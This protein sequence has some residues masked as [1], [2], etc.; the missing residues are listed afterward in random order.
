MISDSL[1]ARAFGRDPAAIGNAV[2]LDDR[3]VTIVGVL[4]D[5]ADFGMRQILSAAAYSRG[6]ADRGE[7]VRVDVWLPLQ[8]DPDTLPRDTHPVFQIG[9]LAAGATLQAAQLEAAGFAA[10]LERAYPSS[11]AGRGVFVEPFGEVVFGR[12]RPALVLLL[13]AVGFVLL[14]ACINVS[15]LVLARGT[16]RAREVAIRTVLGADGWRLMRQFL[17]EGLVLTLSG[18]GLG[19]AVA[20]AGLRGLVAIAPADVPRLGEVAINWTVLGATLA[21][22]V[23][24]GLAFGLVPVLQTRRLDPQ[25]ALKDGG[26]LQASAGRRHGRLR[27]GLVVIEIALAVVL[28][29]G[30]GLL[31]RSFRAL[32]VIDPGFHSEGVLKAEF[33]LPP[34]RYPVDFRKWPNFA[35]IHAFNAALLERA[36]ALPGVTSAAIAGNHPLDAGFTNSFS[37]VGREAEAKSWPEISV[38]R[39]T[40]AYF[41]VVRLPLV[42]GRLFEATDTTGAAPVALVNAAAARRFFAGMDPIGARIT[43]W[44]AQ[45]TVVGVVGDERFQGLSAAPP[46]GLYLP[47]SQAPSANGAGVLLVR[48]SGDPAAAAHDVRAAIRA[49]DPGLAVFGL[50]PLRDTVARSLSERAFTMALLALFAAL[51]IGLAALG[52]H[53]VLSYGVEQRAREIG[54]RVALGARPSGIMARVMGESLVLSAAG[55]AIGLAGAVVLTRLM[56]GLLFGVT[57][58]DP[59]TFGA[60]AVLLL[61]VAVTASLVPARRAARIDPLVTLRA[62]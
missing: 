18:A 40:P 17:V 34:T 49:I 31:V 4:P 6:F 14:V 59:L 41:Q 11:N 53:G 7:R 3:A 60:V 16:A 1:W 43:M 48:T 9:R 54:V 57:P 21:I 39:V 8:P 61:G 24:A 22:S 42:T 15:S 23:L 2:R 13:G 26:G 51:A 46:I 37:V 33:Q 56:S 55:L 30:A 47:L 52:V 12:V 36:E 19:V 58:T 62:E 5:A 28:L 50:E 10:G 45:R 29:A 25:R 38:R 27:A 32:T 20:M 44:G 35:E